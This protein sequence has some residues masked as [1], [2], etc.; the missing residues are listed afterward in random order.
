MRVALDHAFV[1]TVTTRVGRCEVSLDDD[2]E[3]IAEPTA[4][5]VVA[6]T[7]VD[8]SRGDVF[9]TFDPAFVTGDARELRAYHEHAVGEAMQLTTLRLSVLKEVAALLGKELRDLL[10]GAARKG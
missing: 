9:H 8:L 10:P 7:C 6:Q 5:G 1:I 2:G 4:E 3:F